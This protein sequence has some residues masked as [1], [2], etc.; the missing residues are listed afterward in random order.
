MNAWWLYKSYAKQ[1][2]IFETDEVVPWVE[3]DGL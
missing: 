3:R 1:L 2:F